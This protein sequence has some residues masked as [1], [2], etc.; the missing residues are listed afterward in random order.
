MTTFWITWN[1]ETFLKYFKT[2]SKNFVSLTISKQLSI[3]SKQVIKI[4]FHVTFENIAKL[5]HNKLTMFRMILDFE[6]F[7]KYFKTNSK[8]FVSLTISKQF[9]LISKQIIRI[10]FHITFENIAKLFHNKLTMFW[11][12]LNF[13]TIFN[14]FITC[15]KRFE[16][17][18]S[19]LNHILLIQ[20]F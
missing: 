15:W 7:L 6:T 12:T 20:I 10:L 1:F 4:L 11:M 3:N 19:L 16:C 9:S 2:N 5:F 18:D 14:Y 8:N 17:I 13:E